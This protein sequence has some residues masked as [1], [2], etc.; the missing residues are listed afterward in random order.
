[1]AVC[2]QFNTSMSGPVG[3]NYQSL[4]LVARIKQIDLTPELFKDIQVM[5]SEYLKIS[6]EKS[7]DA[8]QK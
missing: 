4:D 1:M 8:K 7:Q 2:T 5:E 3:L 6:R